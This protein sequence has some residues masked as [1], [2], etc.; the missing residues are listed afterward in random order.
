MT[1][2]P[3]RMTVIEIQEPGG[4][5]VLKSRAAPGSESGPRRDPGQVAAAGVNRADVMQRMGLI[6]HRPEPPTFPDLKSRAQSS[7]A[8]MAFRAGRK[9]TR[10][11]P[12]SLAAAMPN[13]ASLMKATPCRCRPALRRS[14]PPPYPRRFS[15]SGTICSSAG[16]LAA[17]E[18]VLIHGG[19]SGI[20]TTAIQLAKAFGALGR[21]HRRFA[22]EMRGLLETRRRRRHQL[23]D[24]GFLSLRPKRPPQTTAPTS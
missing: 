18:T 24:R 5:E 16:R 2:L 20:G 3:K 9:P 21:H 15:P 12:W 19:S 11:W 10:S 1:A 6:R 4:P 7:R 13:I 22:G 17:G 23:Q 14:R 8:A